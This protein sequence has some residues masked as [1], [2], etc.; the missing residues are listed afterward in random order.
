MAMH[1]ELQFL[2]DRTERILKLI[3]FDPYALAAL[4]AGC[5]VMVRDE[6]IAELYLAFPA[7]PDTVY[8]L[9]LLERFK[10]AVHGCTVY[11]AR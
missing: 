4:G 7:V 2:C 10:C 3:R 11:A 5:V 8:E 9:Y 1:A 6:C